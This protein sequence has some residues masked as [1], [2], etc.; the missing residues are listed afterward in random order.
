MKRGKENTSMRVLKETKEEFN[1][2]KAHP[3]E[4]DN[5]TLTRLMDNTNLERGNKKE[6]KY[7]KKNS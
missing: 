6:V 4:V 5:E 2:F 1:T 7:G 3:R